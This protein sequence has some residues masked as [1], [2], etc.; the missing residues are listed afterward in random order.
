MSLNPKTVAA[1]AAAGIVVY[2]LLK[3]EARSAAASVADAVNP[4]NPDNIFY[5][6][7]NGV[8]S[9]LTDDPDFNLG[10]WLYDQIHGNGG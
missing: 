8:G 1:I 4:T 6:G 9:V 7:V 2:I 10:P 5:E 3:N